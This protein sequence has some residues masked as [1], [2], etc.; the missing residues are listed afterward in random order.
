MTV[1][2]TMKA[3]TQRA[4]W[5]GTRIRS[6]SLARSR[7]IFRN[8]VYSLQCS[9]EPCSGEL[10]GVA[11]AYPEVRGGKDV[12]HRLGYQYVWLI[13]RYSWSAIFLYVYTGQIAF[14]TLNSQ[15]V[16]PSE[17]EAQ[18][19]YSQAERESPPGSGCF[20]ASPPGVIV[21]EPCSPKS[22]Y[23]LA[24][25]VCLSPLRSDAITVALFLRLT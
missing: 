1:I 2:S 3:Q 8:S 7:F 16:N 9:R 20:S 17:R 10:S 23:S 22:V 19:D 15:D 21:V 4:L 18:D 13:C 25:K 6:G 14:T 11:R 24:N 12:G 5:S